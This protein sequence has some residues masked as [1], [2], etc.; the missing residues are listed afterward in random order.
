MLLPHNRILCYRVVIP[1]LMMASISRIMRPYV[2]KK[3]G[4]TEATTL[5]SIGFLKTATIETL[6][7]LIATTTIMWIMVQHV[8]VSNVK[9]TIATA[10]IRSLTMSIGVTKWIQTYRRE[11]VVWSQSDCWNDVSR[12]LRTLGS[13]YHHL[14][15]VCWSNDVYGPA[16]GLRTF[17]Y[18]AYNRQLP[19]M[20]KNSQNL[21]NI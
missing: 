16:V 19:L 1:H 6:R 15:K 14:V 20:A 3:I 10:T 12:I 11:I 5:P 17:L 2:L 9:G 13:A 7:M 18:L 8:I 21:I 4:A